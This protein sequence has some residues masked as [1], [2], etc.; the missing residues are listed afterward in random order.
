M[1]RGTNNLDEFVA[2]FY[3]LKFFLD[4]ELFAIQIFG[5]SL[6]VIKWMLEQVQVQNIGLLV[7]EEQVKDIA[8]YFLDII[9]SHI[10]CEKKQ[11]GDILSKEGLVFMENTYVLAEFHGH[12]SIGKQDRLEA[13]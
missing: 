11:V 1:G 2:L 3:L 8:T 12:C 4:K 5:D 13:F 6:M 10:L 9:F 7:V